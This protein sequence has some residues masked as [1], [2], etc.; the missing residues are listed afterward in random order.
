MT[1][2]TAPV[3]SSET[4]FHKVA[5]KERVG[6]VLSDSAFSDLYCIDQLAE[7][8]VEKEFKTVALQF[9]DYALGESARVQHLLTHK[10]DKSVG[11]YVLGDTSY[12]PCC[13]DEVAAQHV[14]ADVVVHFGNTCLSEVTSTPVSYVLSDGVT[15]D[16]E[17]IRSKFE[18][19]YGSDK[20][21]PILLVSDIQYSAALDALYE[22]I[23]S[24]FPNA[25][26]TS[27]ADIDSHSVFPRRN[28]NSLY[29][30]HTQSLLPLRRHPPLPQDLADYSIFYLVNDE[31]SSSLLL[32]LSTLV[33][34]ISVLSVS[35]SASAVSQQRLARSLQKRY[36]YMNEAR[37]ARTIG[38]LVN[39]LSLKNTNSVLDTVKQ[40]I[41]C[42]GKKYYT[43]VVGKPNVPKLANFDVI[44]VWVVLGCPL[45]GL[46]VDC[47]DYYKP[48]ITPYELNQA[49]KSEI[50]W[51]GE[52]PISFDS[53]LSMPVPLSEG[54][55]SSIEDSDAPQF[56]PI[57][58]TYVSTSRPLQ[59][60]DV[61]I[62]SGVA[63]QDDASAGT[64]TSRFDSQM[65]IRNTVST[66]AEYLH[67]RP[68]WK[69]LGSEWDPQEDVSEGAQVKQGRSGIARG[70]NVVGKE[71]EESRA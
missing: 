70:Y 43:I 8:I 6:V 13:V 68:S 52:W 54:H 3:L 56:D 40:W 29:A 57:S 22:H 25:V 34:D 64:L 11:V 10:I 60:I 18:A 65:A 46:I 5:L 71:E 1:S 35:K 15:V 38:I 30:T 61:E 58:G 7:W 36:R 16:S 21:R 17:S 33:A 31:A 62:E 63:S 44:D 12:S 41:T 19:A 24:N 9:P 59:R 67:D 42:A 69:G 50:E 23:K 66:A 26:P 28:T 37:R 2:I 4:T 53:V 47:D 32:H 51:T 27:F 45:G 14:S 55:E 39:T 48:I 49:L 20:T